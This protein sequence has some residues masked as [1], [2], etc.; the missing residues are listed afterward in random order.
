MT[1]GFCRKLHALTV[2]PEAVHTADQ[3]V[4]HL[5]FKVGAAVAPTGDTALRRE[6][7]AIAYLLQFVHRYVADHGVRNHNL[8]DGTAPACGQIAA[9]GGEFHTASHLFQLRLLHTAQYR[10]TQLRGADLL[11]RQLAFPND[12][13]IRFSI[14]DWPACAHP[15]DLAPKT[16]DAPGCAEDKSQILRNGSD[17]GLCD[18]PV[19]FS[20]RVPS[21]NIMVPEFDPFPWDATLQKIQDTCQAVFPAGEKDDNFFILLQRKQLRKINAV[22]VRCSPAAWN[23][24]Q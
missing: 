23:R 14:L 20:V 3:G 21:V 6:L 18:G 2:R 11:L 5:T 4:C 7:S 22:H 24:W 19:H 12:T 9:F 16:I 13:A 10:L 15:V 1:S 17:I 8:E